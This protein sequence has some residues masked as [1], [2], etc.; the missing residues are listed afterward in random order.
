MTAVAVKPRRIQLR[1]TAGW[2]LAEASS[3]PAG[4]V[5]VARPS[6]WGNPFVVHQHTLRA[7]GAD[8]LDCPL[9]EDQVAVDTAAEAVRKLGHVLQYPCQN[10]PWYPSPDEIRWELAGKDLACWCP[11][12][13][14]HADVLLELANS[15]VRS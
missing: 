3:N 14:C 1:R 4:V 11:P 5:N 13:P 12:G 9:H 7:C 8:L 6:K 10:D 2:R 15:E